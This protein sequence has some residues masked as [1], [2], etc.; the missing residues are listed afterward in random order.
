VTTVL[1]IRT[2]LESDRISLDRTAIERIPLDPAAPELRLADRVALRAG[3]ALLL[4]SRRRHRVQD[5]AETRRLQ[6]ERESALR[7]RDRLL[8]QAHLLR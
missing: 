1:E 8:A 6:L 7:E 2:D 4:W 5:P 3:L